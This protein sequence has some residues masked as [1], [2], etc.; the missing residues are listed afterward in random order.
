M[1]AIETKRDNGKQTYKMGWAKYQ[2][3]GPSEEP[4]ALPVSSVAGN[5]TIIADHD[6]EGIAGSSI[7]N[8][9]WL[10]GIDET[11]AVLGA[12]SV[13]G[14]VLGFVFHAI[15]LYTTVRL[16]RSYFR[17][18][19]RIFRP[20]FFASGS[21][22][23]WHLLVV[24]IGFYWIVRRSFEQNILDILSE[25]DFLCQVMNQLPGYYIRSID[26]LTSNFYIRGRFT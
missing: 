6:S 15:M 17:S 14:H 10:A 11:S 3:M 25:D 4:D 1:F 9:D 8:R 12:M 18:R 16:F 5:G 2:G 20:S 23:V 24:L 26:C 22:F 13:L 19:R 21:L 7:P